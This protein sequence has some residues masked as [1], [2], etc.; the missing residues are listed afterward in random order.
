MRK[1]LVV[2][3]NTTVLNTIVRQLKRQDYEVFSASSTPEALFVY[4]REGPIDLIVIDI[5]LPERKSGYQL[6][7]TLR[8]GNPEQK[9]LMISGYP[10]DVIDGYSKPV[11]SY[12]T[13]GKPFRMKEFREVIDRM[14]TE[15]AC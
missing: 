7:D 14:L 10:K 3:D 4:R 2:D 6:A 9:I 1:I 8:E 11:N 15:T 13:L 12:P 5:V